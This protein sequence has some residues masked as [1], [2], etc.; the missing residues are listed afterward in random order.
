[1][2]A[3]SEILLLLGIIFSFIN[4]LLRIIRDVVHFIAHVL[5][6]RVVSSGLSNLALCLADGLFGPG[7]RVFCGILGC[8][9][10]AFI[11]E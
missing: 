11:G 2:R 8:C 9:A 1:M 3:R 6:C 4:I 10:R 7:F 5:R